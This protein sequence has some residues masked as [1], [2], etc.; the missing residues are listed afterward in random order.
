MDSQDEKDFGSS[1]DRRLNRLEAIS[2]GQAATLDHMNRTLMDIS[3]RVNEPTQT[4]WG[5][6]ISAV[7][8][9]LMLAGGYTTVITQPIDNR[10]MVN[11]QVDKRQDEI[12]YER[13]WQ[14]GRSMATVSNLELWTQNREGLDEDVAT[15]TL[16]VQ[17]LEKRIERMEQREDLE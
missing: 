17:Q 8:V 12:L 13:G 11:E 3:S 9:V 5:W 14:M 4:N 6:L 16:Y 2:T 7:T 15:N 1:F 10:L